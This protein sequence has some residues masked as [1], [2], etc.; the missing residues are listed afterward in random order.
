MIFERAH[1][2]ISEPKICRFQNDQV[3]YLSGFTYFI[4]LTVGKNWNINLPALR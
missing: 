2:E 3:F 4:T 1:I